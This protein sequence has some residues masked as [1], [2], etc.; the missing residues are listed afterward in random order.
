MRS[1]ALIISGA[2]LGKNAL[3]PETDANSS[4]VSLPFIPPLRGRE[5]LGNTYGIDSGGGLP[6]AAPQFV[7]AV[8]RSIIFA[9]TNQENRS[10]LIS[11]T[12]YF[13]DTQINSVVK[14]GIAVWLNIGQLSKHGI[15]VSRPLQQQ[16]GLRIKIDQEILVAVVARL[17]EIG[18]GFFGSEAFVAIHRTRCVEDNSDMEAGSVFVTEET[19]LLRHFIV[20]YGEGIF[21]G[22]A[23]L[24]RENQ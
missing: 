12:H 19:D 9:V 3:P 4:N 16:S 17:Y 11:T 18:E 8:P 24:D 20:E 21:P 15:A 7:K 14:R 13:L 10:L 6:K 1:N 22:L 23:P 5:F 2:P